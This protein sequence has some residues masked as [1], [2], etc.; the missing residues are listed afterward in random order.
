MDKKEIDEQYVL[1]L[2]RQEEY[3]KY[4]YLFENELNNA[5][6]RCYEIKE[7]LAAEGINKKFLET[8][9]NSK[10]YS[11]LTEYFQLDYEEISDNYNNQETMLEQF[12][13]ENFLKSLKI[14]NKKLEEDTTYLKNLYNKLSIFFKEDREMN[15]AQ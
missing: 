7:F 14:A 15:S 2:E 9:D 3:F 10:Y 4:F 11:K 1:F 12:D 5:S 6:T 8:M 13:E